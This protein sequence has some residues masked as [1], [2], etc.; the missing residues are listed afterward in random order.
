M[1]KFIAFILDLLGFK[2]IWYKLNPSKRIEGS[3]PRTITLWLI[4]IMVAL[5]SITSSRYEQELTRLEYR[6]SNL[7]MQA[8]SSDN[9]L[10][11]ISKLQNRKIPY[12]PSILNPLSTIKSFFSKYDWVDLYIITELQDLLIRKKTNLVILTYNLLTLLLQ[13]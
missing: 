11:F 6:V 13:I 1:F 4:S 9:V 12:K 2:Y 3:E 10:S 5:Y 8:E 7:I